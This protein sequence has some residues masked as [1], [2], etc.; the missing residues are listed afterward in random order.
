MR[1]VMVIG[2]G[3]SGVL[4]ASRYLTSATHKPSL[5]IL[6][7]ESTIG[8][9]LSHIQGGRWGYGLGHISH[10]LFQYLDQTLKFHP[11]AKDLPEFGIHCRSSLGLF[12]ANQIKQVSTNHGLDRQNAAHLAGASVARDWE[13]IEELMVNASDTAKNKQSVAQ[14]WSGDRRSPSATVLESLALSA[15]IPDVW[16]ARASVIH[17]R[18]FSPSRFSGGWLTALTELIQRYQSSHGLEVV[19]NCQV[20]GAQKTSDQYWNIKTTR[21]VYH[22]KRLVAAQPPWDTLNWLPKEYWP[23]PILDLVL[24]TKPVSVISLCE[25]VIEAQTDMPPDLTLMPAEKVQISFDEGEICYQGTL[26]YEVSL[27]DPN[28][29]KAVRRLKRARRKFH[30]FYSK[31]K[32]EGEYL[33]LLPSGWAQ[34]YEAAN[35]KW[36]GKLENDR[37]QQPTLT[38]CGDAYGHEANCDLNIIHSVNS[39]CQQFL[40]SQDLPGGT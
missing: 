23:K 9:R 11:E 37:F 33:A 13:C 26:P 14:L 40:D 1:D 16:S 35:A 27:Q 4:L 6:E 7:K 3:I 20:V 17:Q 18:L 15:G 24:K 2:G 12:S 10:D 31:M 36:L 32:V 21:G 8:G 30:Q 28:V 39:A 5:T 22:A 29:V 25:Q 19:P 34:A 38:F